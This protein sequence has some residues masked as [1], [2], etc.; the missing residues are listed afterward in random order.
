VTETPEH[1]GGAY[2]VGDANTFMPDV[3]QHLIDTF[4]IRS[5]V[6]IGCGYGH[7]TKWF[8]DHGLHA[9][10]IEGDPAAVEGTKCPGAIVKHDYTLGPLVIDP[11]D[12]AWSAEFVEHVQERFV[13]NFMATFN[14]CRHAVITH[15]EP[16]QI[17][18]YHVNCQPS[19]YW[20]REFGRLGFDHNEQETRWMRSTDQGTGAWGRRTLMMFTKRHAANSDIS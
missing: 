2:E 14:C 19:W 1:L 10:G 15:G 16:G 5:V 7:S 18:H 6:D 12:L 4:G 17:G 9:T 20:I 8:R 13:R 3:W 11:T